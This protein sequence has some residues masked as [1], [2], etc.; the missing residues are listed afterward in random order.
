MENESV[1]EY[2]LFP[3]IINELSKLYAIEENTNK[4]YKYVNMRCS[5]K[6]NEKKVKE[7][8][9]LEF[10]LEELNISVFTDGV[11]NYIVYKDVKYYNYIWFRDF[12]EN[13]KFRAEIEGNIEYKE[14]LLDIHKKGYAKAN[15]FRQLKEHKDYILKY[16]V[17]ML[18]KLFGA[19]PTYS[20]GVKGFKKSN[21]HNPYKRSLEESLEVII[22]ASEFLGSNTTTHITEEQ[23][24]DYLVKNLYLIEEGMRFIDRQVDIQ[25]G[26]IDILARDREENLCVIEVK[27]KEDKSLIWQSI[28]YPKE[29]KKKYKVKDLRM[30][31]VAPSYRKHILDTLKEIHNLE[32]MNYTINV[33]MGK[34]DNLKLNIVKGRNDFNE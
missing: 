2:D 33:S 22:N 14:I 17:E 21:E 11:L 8:Q 32:I 4:L 26:I 18:N 29:I 30:I 10:I 24:E 31:T 3:I 20:K 9:L 34:I 19:T 5:I 23:L 6:N 12:I 16:R 15:K 7:N 27:I 13:F 25:G 1:E 28:H